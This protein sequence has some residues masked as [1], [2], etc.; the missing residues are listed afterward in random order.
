MKHAALAIVLLSIALGCSAQSQRMRNLPNFDMKKY[1]FGFLLSINSSDFA[2]QYKPDYTFADSLQGISNQAQS[3][4]NLALLASLDLTPNIH[5]RFLP[6]LSF[7][8][9]GLDYRFL[10]E[11]EPVSILKRTESVF[12]EFPL[13]L[14]L[15]TN[16]VNNFAAYGLIGGKYGREMQ[17]QKDVNNLGGDEVIIRLRDNDFAMEVGGGFDFFLPFFKLSIEMKTAFGFQNL[18]IQEPTIFAEPLESLRTR[19]FVFSIAFEG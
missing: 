19:M 5:L 10:R 17:S 1:H 14:K 2:F 18:L 13:L 7:Q 12:L 8:D 16:R 15:R 4:F 6:G 11:N 3:G 9:R